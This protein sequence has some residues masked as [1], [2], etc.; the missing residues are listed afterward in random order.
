MSLMDWDSFTVDGEG[1]QTSD[2]LVTAMGV[3]AEIYK[4]DVY[5][6]DPAAWVEGCGFFHPTVAKF[7]EGHMKYKDLILH[8][9]RCAD[10]DAIVVVA[11]EDKDFEAPFKAMAGFGTF[12][13]EDQ[14]WD[15]F[16]DQFDQTIKLIQD[17]DKQFKLP[18]PPG[19]AEVM[20]LGLLTRGK[21]DMIT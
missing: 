13:L 1:R 11:Y 9:R 10:V 19:A 16:G 12:S 5:I 3:T 14:G 4:S 8:A 6:Q 20:C 21:R 17:L 18:I 7:R 2:V 15:D